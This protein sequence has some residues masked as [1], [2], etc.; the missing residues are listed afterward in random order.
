MVGILFEV[1]KNIFKKCNKPE[2]SKMYHIFIKQLNN[3]CNFVLN[4]Y[5]K[6]APTSLSLLIF[7]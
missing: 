5:G 3:F 1:Y 4:M 6:S 2:I 7:R